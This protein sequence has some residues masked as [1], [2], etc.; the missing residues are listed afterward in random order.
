MKKLFF[1]FVTVLTF[2]SCDTDDDYTNYTYDYL[3]TEEATIPEDMVVGDTYE[4]SLKYIQPS[5]CYIFDSL[6]YYKTTETI[7]DEEDENTATETEVR[8]IAVINR[9]LESSDTDCVEVNEEVETSF[10]FIPEVSGPYLFKFWTGLDED[11]ED[12]FLEVERDI[13]DGL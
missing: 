12:V 13:A 3:P 8:T 11:G 1:L 5:T 6:Y 9:V 10:T 2:A 4:I 7:E